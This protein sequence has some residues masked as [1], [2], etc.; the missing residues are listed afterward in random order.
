MSRSR[1]SPPRTT[2]RVF[3]VGS[4]NVFTDLGFEDAVELDLKVRLAV[5]IVRLIQVRHGH[6]VGLQ[7]D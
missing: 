1:R 4:G 7:L 2:L 3:E 5:Q 6:N